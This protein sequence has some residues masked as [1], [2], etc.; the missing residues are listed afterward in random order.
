MKRIL[1]LLLALCLMLPVVAMADDAVKIGQVQFAAHGTSCFAVLTVA[2]QGDTIVAAYIDE[3]QFMSAEGDRP[4][5]GVPNSDAGFGGNYPEGMV[6]ASKKVNNDLYSFNM[7]DHGGATQELGTSYAAIEAFV[8]GKTIAELE[9]AVSGY[10]AD[11]KADFIDVV[12][13]STLADTL[14][15]VNGLIAAAKA[16]Q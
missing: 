3:F 4:A 2:M 7:S 5:E 8:V 10:T 15:Y 16:A 6:L 14:G 1:C 11:N 12:S 13:G 9:D